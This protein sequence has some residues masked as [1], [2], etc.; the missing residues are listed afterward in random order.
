MLRRLHLPQMVADQASVRTAG[1]RALVEALDNKQWYDEIADRDRRIRIL[2]SF[3]ADRV[4]AYFESRREGLTMAEVEARMKLVGLN[5]LSVRKPLQWWRILLHSLPDPFNIL[6]VALAIIAVVTPAP[7]WPNF[8]VLMTM[9]VFSCAVRFWHEWK[10]ATASV[11]L[12]ARNASK[13]IVRRH[14]PLGAE[15]WKEEAVDMK[16]IVP[17]D[18][19]VLDPGSSVP[20]DCL[21]LQANRLQVSQSGLT[22]ESDPQKKTA[23]SANTEDVDIF[24]LQ[25]IAFMGTG[26]DIF[27]LQNIAFMGTG[28]V[29]G[30]GLALVLA[31]GD[32][33]IRAGMTQELNKHKPRSVFDQGLWRFT[34]LMIGFMVV[35]VSV[36]LVVH[37]VIS[38]DWRSAGVFSLAIA[39]GLVPVMLPAVL[40][41]N[42]ARGSRQLTKRGATVKNLGAV[43]DLG[44]MTVL[45]SDKTGTLTQDDITLEAA[46]DG[47]GNMCV[48]VLKLAYTNV[49]HQSGIKNDIDAAILCQRIVSPDQHFSLDDSHCIS[50]IPF[51]FE[52]RRSSVI[53]NTK[54]EQTTLICKGAFEEVINRCTK[55]RHGALFVEDGVC[56]VNLRKHVAAYNDDGYRVLAVATRIL[57]RGDLNPNTDEDLDTDM[58]FE[59]LLKFLDPPRDDAKAT[60]KKLQGLGVEVKIL[61]G[62]NL[63]SARGFYRRL[64]I[65]SDDIEGQGGLRAVTGPW[66]S[67]MNKEEFDNAVKEASVLAKLTPAQKADVIRS[68]RQDGQCVGM[69]GDGINDCPA[70]AVADVGISVNNA[71]AVAKDCADIIL[72]KEELWTI[73]GAIGIGR[74]THGNTMKYIK[75]VASSNFGNVLSIL[76]ASTWLPY[77]PMTARQI[78]FQN[79]LY[80]LSQMAIPWDQMDDEYLAVP[81]SWDM[82]ELLRFIMC[83]GP[84][85]SIVDIVT[86]CS[87]WFYFGVRTADD[88]V[89]VAMVQSHWFL[90]GLLTQLLIVHV[91]RT[92][93]IP[94]LESR[95]ATPLAMT[96]CI[97]MVIGLIIPILLHQCQVLGL[98]FPAGEFIGFLAAELVG[99]CIL[100]QLVKMVYVWMTGEWL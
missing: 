39:V 22:G 52:K 55:T 44:S 79:L 11:R 66:L 88:A 7:S 95:A 99:Y 12:Q 58:V 67:G 20:A 68:L 25:N 13:A 51:D 42:L 40:N 38:K 100:V 46:E 61:T 92:A 9:I 62:D 81:H 43:Q 15:P 57:L 60:I 85:S 75:M 47:H 50:E 3:Q 56:W 16:N 83:L 48:E 74:S 34:C 21:V 87:S 91:L 94:F 41:T 71:V 29:S 78:L 32:R 89:G 37:G 33:V 97:I 59:G 76:A 65:S 27:D 31:T 80:D 30:T 10:G 1:D 84:V 69:L 73:V 28:V 98:G 93:K 63:C 4:L 70:L 17:G 26:V 72:T 24:D 35:M 6:L 36:A 64:N 82:W 54:S 77:Q 14:D 86:F 2:A 49:H 23:V 96:T 53:V 8:A 5:V 45:C 18:I 90:Q 19:L